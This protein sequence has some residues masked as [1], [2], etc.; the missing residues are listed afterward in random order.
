MQMEEEEE[1]FF[2][3]MVATPSPILPQAGDD[4]QGADDGPIK[5]GK[6]RA[7]GQGKGSALMCKVCKQCSAKKKQLY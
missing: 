2:E 7:K 3:G 1:T 6:G 4:G 5:S